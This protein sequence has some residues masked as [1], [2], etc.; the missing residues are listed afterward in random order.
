MCKRTMVRFLS[1]AAVTSAAFLTLLFLVLLAAQPA[2]AAPIVSLFNTG[3][4]TNDSNGNPQTLVSAGSPDPHYSTGIVTLSNGYP[5]GVAWTPDDST[6]QWISPHADEITIEPPGLYVYQTT[7]DLTG[8]NPSTAEISG[9]FWVDNY[10]SDIILNST[11]TG[12]AGGTYS[13][14]TSFTLSSGFVSGINTLDFYVINGPTGGAQNP[15][16]LRVAM[17]GTAS[18]TGSFTWTGAQNG[19]WDTS[20]VNW[21]NSLSSTA[22]YSDGS[23]VVFNDTNAL[24]GTKVSNTNITISG[25]V[26][27]QSITFNNTG[28]ANGGVDYTVGGGAIVGAAA[29]IKN[30]AGTVTLTGA[31][32]YTGTTTINDGVFVAGASNTLSP[33]SAVNV[34]GGTLDASGYANTVASLTVTSGGLK[35]GVGN[36]LTSTGAAVL[37]GGIN[38]NINGAGNSQPAMVAA[39][40]NLAGNLTVSL[41]NGFTPTS[42]DPFHVLSATSFSGSFNTAATQAG[43]PAN[44]VVQATYNGS[45]AGSFNVNYANNSVTLVYQ[46]LLMLANLSNN[47]YH[48]LQGYGSYTYVNGL[49]D[50]SSGFLANEYVSAD[51]S[52][53]VIAFRGTDS[54][55]TPTLVKNVAADV[56]FAG[57]VPSPLLVSEVTDA[58]NFVKLVATNNTLDANITLTGHSLGG[59]IAQLVGKASGLDTYAFDAP[60]ALQD[61]AN[62]SDVLSGISGTPVAGQI[63]TDYRLYGD[64]VSLMGTPIGNTVTIVNPNTPTLRSVMDGQYIF[65]AHSLPT[66]ISQIQSN[67]NNP[68]ISQAPAG[69]SP[70]L[71]VAGQLQKYITG[72][73]G[74]AGQYA[75]TFVVTNVAGMLL[76][77]TGGMDFSFVENS[78]SPDLASITLPIL[79]GVAGYDVRYLQNGVWSGFQLIKPGVEDDLPIG[80]NGIDFDPVD[81]SGKG[82]AV[83]EFLFQEGFYSTGTVSATLTETTVPEP[84]TVALL[85]VGAIGLLAFAWRR[86]RKAE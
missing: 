50:T 24:T 37:N 45:P 38:V 51:G 70:E 72:T 8:L 35:L 30:G 16:G 62:L 23:A 56:S 84:S 47:I 3:V 33:N 19:S 20:T 54:S 26:S 61:Y 12:I 7:F 46:P 5:I 48:N 36:T 1:A 18:T 68:P 28:A 80:V 55:D 67:P 29:L 11:D 9:S 86:R 77:P 27:P 58:V 10:L 78:G 21:V 4:A 64:Q 82:V 25:V 57:S 17:T 32:T 71:N 85:S 66:L 34:S 44:R 49:L 6:S 42:G 2:F 73:P 59:A 13:S 75:F 53:I 81:S 31:N 74:G 83:S 22:T 41:G 14:P 65:G 60:G 39:S 76:D 15:S 40:A 52:Q 69:Q 63:N 43:I 79:D